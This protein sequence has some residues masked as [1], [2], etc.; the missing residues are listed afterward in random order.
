MAWYRWNRETDETYPWA[1]FKMDMTKEE[2]EEYLKRMS[3]MEWILTQPDG[4]ERERRVAHTNFDRGF[5]LS[6][7][8]LA[9]DHSWGGDPVLFETMTFPDCRNQWRYHTGK[10]AKAHHEQLVKA[11]KL[12]LRAPR[13]SRKNLERVLNQL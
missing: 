12:C 4:F 9:L 2:E 8:F 3:Y 5:K 11:I 10:E 7:V 13:I 6:T 1:E